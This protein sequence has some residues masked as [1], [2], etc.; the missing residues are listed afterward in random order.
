M[1][2]KF[3]RAVIC[4]HVSFTD[5]YL[6]LSVVRERLGKHFTLRDIPFKTGTLNMRLGQNNAAD[7][8]EVYSLAATLQ[9]SQLRSTQRWSQTLSSAGISGWRRRMS[10]RGG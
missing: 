10:V 7:L 8:Y 5:R 2:D 6:P 1:I 9:I 3:R 4:L